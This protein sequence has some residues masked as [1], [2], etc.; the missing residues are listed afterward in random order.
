[1]GD[2]PVRLLDQLPPRHPNHVIA[3]VFERHRLA[4]VP[5]ERP[6]VAVKGDRVDLEDDAVLRP[7]E[8]DFESRDPPVDPRRLRQSRRLEQPLFF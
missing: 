6:A 7:E 4:P 2:H 8:V 1:M 3:R 5:V